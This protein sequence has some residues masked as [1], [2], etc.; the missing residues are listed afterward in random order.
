MIL[1]IIVLTVTRVACATV[2]KYFIILYL[3]ICVSHPQAGMTNILF[4]PGR[5]D[6]ILRKRVAP[7]KKAQFHHCPHV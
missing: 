1:I 7:H 3:T 5:L 4:P 2:Y 6:F